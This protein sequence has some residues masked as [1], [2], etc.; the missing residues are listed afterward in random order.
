MIIFEIKKQTLKKI[1]KEYFEFNEID[2]NLKKQVDYLISKITDT[3]KKELIKKCDVIFYVKNKESFYQ[4]PLST[5]I[6]AVS[7]LLKTY[8]YY[9]I[10]ESE[11]LNEDTINIFIDTRSKNEIET[12]NTI[13]AILFLINYTKNEK[14]SV[15]DF[16][17]I[18]N[19]YSN[20]K[21]N[22]AKGAQKSIV[23]TLT[24]KYKERIFR[25]YPA[26]KSI[27]LIEELK[28]ADKLDLKDK[29]F[30]CKCPICQKK[31]IIRKE[32]IDNII[33]FQKNK[34]IFKC[35]HKNTEY[36]KQ[37]PFEKELDVY[38]SGNNYTNNEKQMFFINN[39]KKLV[40]SNE[41]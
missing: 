2:L 16:D 18:D 17:K 29:E 30:N 13:D 6:M 22:I 33:K 14:S 32:N 10:L 37:L 36:S 1:L 38:L 39:F 7:N 40:E 35:N 20:S 5:K 23:T 28:K 25:V 19:L 31:F 41:N 15:I 27:I 12:L 9:K 4:E 34:V 3:T 26:K 21:K 8:M 24:K 11:E